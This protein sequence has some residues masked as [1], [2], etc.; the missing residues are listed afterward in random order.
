MKSRAINLLPPF[1][2]RGLFWGELYF[3]VCKGT[4]TNVVKVPVCGP[5]LESDGCCTGGFFRRI[6]AVVLVVVL[7]SLETSVSEERMGPTGT[8]LPPRPVG[9]GCKNENLNNICIRLLF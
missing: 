6:V 4:F 5:G 1:G 8:E 3:M 9:N 2:L 7:W